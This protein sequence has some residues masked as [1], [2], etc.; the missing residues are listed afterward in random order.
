MRNL[1]TVSLRL[2]AAAIVATGLTLGACS[3]SHSSHAGHD[4]KHHQAAAKADIVDTAAAAGSFKT[5]LAAATAADLLDT[6]KSD[7][8][9]TVFAPTD[10]AFSKLPAGTVESLLKPENREQLR[11]VLTYHVVPGR[12]TAEQVVK[13]KSL[14]TVQGQKLSV[15]VNSAGVSIDNASVQATDI[16]ASNGVIHV[17]D[18]VVLPKS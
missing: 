1:A 9:F 11:A 10:D 12:M 15:T 3:H 5:L 16:I 8:P 18:T 7:G 14:A 6:L 4:G 2:S 13:Q 17:I